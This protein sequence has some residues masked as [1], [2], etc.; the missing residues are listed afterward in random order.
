MLP[1]QI[2]DRPS[3]PITLPRKDTLAMSMTVPSGHETLIRDHSSE[4]VQSNG[5]AQTPLSYAAARES[6]WRSSAPKRLRRKPLPADEAWI[7][8]WS[9]RS[10]V[11]SIAALCGA[12][13]TPLKWALLDESLNPATNEL[14]L[15]ADK[16][17]AGRDADRFSK[18]RRRR[19]L[20]AALSLWLDAATTAPAG[21]DLAVGCLAAAH[22]LN[23]AGGAISPQLG[24]RLIDVLAETARHAQSSSAGDDETPAASVVQQMLAGELPLTLA[25]FF[26]EMAPLYAMG[27]V[28]SDRLSEGF[29]ELLNG[30]GL[31][32]ARH[33]AMLRPLLACWTR[34]RAIGNE[35]KKGRWSK[36]AQ[37]EYEW[38][39]LQSLR[40]TAPDGGPLLAADVAQGW[41]AE[42]LRAALQFGGTTKDAAAARELLG[43]KA[44]GKEI[45]AAKK[46]PPSSDNCEWS[47][48]AV[49][50]TGWSPGDATIAVDYSTP[51]MRLDAWAGGRRLLAG[52]WLF[53]SHADGAVLR[54]NGNWENV[55]WFTDKDV[56]YLEFMLPL[57]SGARLERQ[58]LLAHR[59]RFL[60]LADHL[61]HARSAELGHAW[62]LP[63]GAGVLF[64]GEGETRDALLVDGTPLA[65]AIP[66][67]LPEWRIDPRVGELSFAGSDVRLTQRTRARNMACPVLVDLDADRCVEPTTWRQ[68]TVGE[69]LQIQPPEVA[70]SYRIQAGD[71][72]WLYYRSQGPRGNRTFMGQNTS[73]EFVMARFKAPEGQVTQ[74]LEIEG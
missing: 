21:Y 29:A 32:H 56:D 12:S 59:D 7:E 10:A 39:V 3:N 66:L 28:A 61:Q 44:L 67:S 62:Q 25:Y 18:G 53:E 65:R 27:T 33:L 74:L 30:Q 15:L 1:V 60:L 14:L 43:K 48:L 4:L 70:V 19:K 35:M 68:L 73:S 13:S 20:Q 34:C 69:Q 63:L 8:Y 11:P 22:I 31:P 36:K 16:I 38:L 49:M 42:P 6:F 54:P 52:P 9:K 40:W 71:Q 45:E 47:C 64:C 55:C 37:V 41:D 24:W 5:K 2:V 72:Q 50:R 26:A 58:I 51:R 23:E 57:E 17:A 46:T